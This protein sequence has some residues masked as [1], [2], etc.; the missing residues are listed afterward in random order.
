M[1]KGCEKV[2]NKDKPYKQHESVIVL[3]PQQEQETQSDLFKRN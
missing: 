1:L 2:K 3:L